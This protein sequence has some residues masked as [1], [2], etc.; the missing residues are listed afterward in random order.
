MD[1]PWALH[2]FYR[3]CSAFLQSAPLSTPYVRASGRRPGTRNAQPKARQP[4]GRSAARLDSDNRRRRSA[5]HQ[6]THIDT[7]IGQREGE[8]ALLISPSPYRHQHLAAKQA[9]SRARTRMA[10]FRTFR[11]PLGAF[12]PPPD[13]RLVQ[14][15]TRC[16][17]CHPGVPMPSIGARPASRD[18]PGS[19]LVP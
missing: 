8:L 16:V 11:K 12:H 14:V 2:L 18:R 3:R 5:H 15:T 4:L 19:H 10:H 9:A 17:V 1:G 13:S 6:H 7:H